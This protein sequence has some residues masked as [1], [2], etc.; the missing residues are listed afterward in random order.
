MLLEFTEYE[1][2]LLEGDEIKHWLET[3]ERIEQ[4][5]AELRRNLRENECGEWFT[6]KGLGGALALAGVARSE[7]RAEQQTHPRINTA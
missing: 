1:H 7:A 2:S 6:P 5:C 4:L 3:E